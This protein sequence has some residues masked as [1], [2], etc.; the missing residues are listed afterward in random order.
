MGHDRF[1]I[2]DESFLCLIYPRALDETSPTLAGAFVAAAELLGGAAERVSIVNVSMEGEGW[3][4]V[5]VE[6]GE[7]FFT[8]TSHD[9]M[10]EGEEL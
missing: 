9:P 1:G 6:G 2:V 7:T 3:D 10:P 4:S 8:I 5:A